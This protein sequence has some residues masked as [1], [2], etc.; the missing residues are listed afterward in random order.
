[1]KYLETIYQRNE[2]GHSFKDFCFDAVNTYPL[3]EP[4]WDEFVLEN[5]ILERG[6]IAN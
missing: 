6:G 5:L 3:V 4:I 2:L 1:M